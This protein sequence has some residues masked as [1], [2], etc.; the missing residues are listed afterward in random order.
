M[1]EQE[2]L[3][4]VVMDWTV[5]VAEKKETE[6]WSRRLNGRQEVKVWLFIIA[7]RKV[8]QLG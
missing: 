7:S 6:F 5:L 4:T 2:A 1:T 3:R 8:G